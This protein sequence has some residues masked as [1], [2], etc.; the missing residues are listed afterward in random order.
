MKFFPLKSIYLSFFLIFVTS[1]CAHGFS[2]DLKK[3]EISALIKTLASFKD[4][5]TGT[6]GCERT[7]GFIKQ[8][9]ESIG[10]DNTGSMTFTLPV[11]MMTKSRIVI[12]NLSFELDP[13]RT[14]AIT[15]QTTGPEGLSGP[16]VYVGFGNLSDFNGKNIKGSILIMEFD[17]GKNWL[18]AANFGAKAVI[19]IE[20]GEPGRMF[21]EDKK[22]LS[23]INFPRFFIT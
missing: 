4:R 16:V 23:P 14:N 9:F 8:A 21:F 5:S 13:L 22:D 11:R 19:Y 1:L 20:R 7:A 3:N 17:S 18:N 15:P 10:P 6:K 12:N 2:Y